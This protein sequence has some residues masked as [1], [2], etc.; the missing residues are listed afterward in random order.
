MKL[1]IADVCEHNKKPS[2]ANFMISFSE[3]NH[4]LFRTLDSVKLKRNTQSTNV[5]NLIAFKFT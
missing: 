4:T 1:G 5:S 2:V 3:K